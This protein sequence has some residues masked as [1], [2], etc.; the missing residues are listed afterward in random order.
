MHLLF[1]LVESLPRKYIGSNDERLWIAVTDADY[2]VDYFG[3]END[4]SDFDDY[5]EPINVS[6]VLSKMFL[7]C[8]KLLYISDIPNHLFFIPSANFSTVSTNKARAK[9]AVPLFWVKRT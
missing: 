9:R 4:D 5:R 2:L 8:Y 1:I 6:A 7:M 3:G